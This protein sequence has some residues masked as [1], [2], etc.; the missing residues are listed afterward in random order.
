MPDPVGAKISVFWP[1]AMAG[2]PWAWAAVGAR[3]LDSNQAATGAANS[4]S[5][6]S[7]ATAPNLGSAPAV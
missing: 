2:Q 5:G 7:G 1:A 6:S 4:E 3:K